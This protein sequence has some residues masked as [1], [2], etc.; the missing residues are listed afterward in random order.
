MPV[1]ELPLTPNG[2]VDHGALPEPEWETIGGGEEFVPPQ[3]ETER[4]V[5]EIWGDVLSV[6]EIG[7]HD[8]FFSLG[9]HSLL[10]MQVMSR[11]HDEFGVSLTL[12]T[13]FDAPTVVKLAA[14]VDRAEAASPLAAP[15]LVRV[16]RTGLRR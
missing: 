16:E 15:T 2:K 1:D 8:N 13:I 3:T 10:A 11:L 4:R 5:V 6:A 14:E 9:G 7:V 12:R